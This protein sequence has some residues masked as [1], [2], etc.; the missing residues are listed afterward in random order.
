MKYAVSEQGVEA[1][2]TMSAA[3]FSTIDQI[4]GLTSALSACA[5]DHADTLGPHKASIDEVIE[6]IEA[7]TKQATEPT[8]SIADTLNEI[9]EAYREIID[10]D[11]IRSSGK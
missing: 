10:N 11:T 1:L 3:I 5:G 6:E 4:N 2:K 7:A 9:A 8:S